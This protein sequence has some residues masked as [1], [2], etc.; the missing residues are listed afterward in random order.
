[1]SPTPEQKARVGIDAALEAAGW[2]I[3][4]RA[5]M[6]LAAGQGVAERLC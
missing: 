2:I 6:N 4:D 1:M 5:M 3:Q